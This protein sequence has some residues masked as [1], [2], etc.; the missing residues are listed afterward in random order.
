MLGLGVMEVVEGEGF[1][2]LIEA[3]VERG[4]VIPLL[5]GSRGMGYEGS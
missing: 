1:I 5:Q 4:K 2:F 3:Q